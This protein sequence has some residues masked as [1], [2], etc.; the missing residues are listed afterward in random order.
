MRP[1]LIA[2]I[3]FVLAARASAACLPVIEGYPI[4][5]LKPGG[6]WVD[7]TALLSA[8]TRCPRSPGSWPIL[9]T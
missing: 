8:A 4:E 9:P 6:E 7:L 2:L 5:P 3:S 1:V